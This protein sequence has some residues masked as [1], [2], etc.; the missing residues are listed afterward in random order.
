MPMRNTDTARRHLRRLLPMTAAVMLAA[1]G[2][3]SAHAQQAPKRIGHAPLSV[4]TIAADAAVE[5][6]A[7]VA[8]ARQ[9]GRLRVIV[10]LT[11]P[12]TPEN[13]LP[14]A[15]SVAQRAQLTRSQTAVVAGLQS[16][17]VIRFATIPYLVVDTDA[18]GLQSL[19]ANPGVASVQ[20]D[21]V[22][23]VALNQSVP[24][25]KA[26]QAAAR[27][28]TGSGQTVAI[29][30]TG[31]D[32]THPMLK[33]KVVSEAC[34][35]TTNSSDGAAS[36]CPGGAQ[37]SIAAGSG[38]NCKLFG[39]EHGTHVASIAAG[40]AAALKGVARGAKIISIQVYSN[41]GG[42]PGAYFSDIVAGLERVYQLRKKFKIASAN[43]SL[44]TEGLDYAS[45][46]DKTYPS[47]KAII[48]NLRSAG[49]ATVIA[50]GNDGTN[51]GVSAPGC[52]STA[53][54]VGSTT[55]QD[56][57]SAFSNQ[58]KLVDL[59]A[60]G[61]EIYAA[62]PGGYAR[63][64]G[65]SMATPHVT[66]AWAV[67]KQAKPKASVAE[68]QA[69]LTCTGV[70]VSRAGVTKPRIDVLAALNVLRSPATGCH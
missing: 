19:L 11:D 15:A 12:M 8:T 43:L 52:V 17:K 67:L 59:M 16:S 38:K 32:K 56:K 27:G 55:K 10:G 7:M 64:S 63:M 39:C 6:A 24:L 3:G 34:Y 57:V 13:L 62:I 47:V 42:A 45:A 66:G 36:L 53:V 14:A 1:A 51:G 44:G 49:I 2:A 33:G 48:D 60:P 5:S 40:N 30:D 9:R 58:S 21:I 68:I 20:E 35:S 4:D 65:T 46:C 54:T 23:P 18:A 31:V 29:L 50:S 41:Y 25:I 70:P 22:V 61:S 28:Y 37:S 26:D 69:A